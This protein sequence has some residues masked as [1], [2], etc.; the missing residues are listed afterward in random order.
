MYLVKITVK[1][2]LVRMNILIMFLA[3]VFIAMAAQQVNAKNSQNSAI[4]NESFTNISENTSGKTN[5]SLNQ[6]QT[7]DSLTSGKIL[8]KQQ[9]SVIRIPLRRNC[10]GGQIRS[11]SGKCVD[12][13][14]NED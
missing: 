12:V 8:K 13:F 1:Y 7:N 6:H 4:R 2:A 14:P 5:I 11:T 10:E 9:N 3:V